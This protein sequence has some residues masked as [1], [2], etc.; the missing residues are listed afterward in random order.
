VRLEEVE[1]LSWRGGDLRWLPL[2]HESGTAFIE[3]A[4]FEADREG[5]TVIER[6][7]ESDDGRAHEEVYPPQRTRLLPGLGWP[8]LSVLGPLADENRRRKPLPVAVD[9]LETCLP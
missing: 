5:Q 2:R 3:T 4:A 9:V 7:V 8:G 1:G 6:H